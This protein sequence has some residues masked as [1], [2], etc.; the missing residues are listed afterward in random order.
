MF[1]DLR[2][3][4]TTQD[5]TSFNIMYHDFKSVQCKTKLTVFEGKP[6]L[7]VFFQTVEIKIKHR[8]KFF[9]SPITL[10]FTG[11]SPLYEY[12]A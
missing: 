12:A 8:V 2:L 5:L 9:S 10:G 3:S 6:L 1:S 7:T 4:N 11:L